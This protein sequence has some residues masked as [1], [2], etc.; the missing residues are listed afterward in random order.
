MLQQVHFK[1]WIL[2]VDKEATAN[3]Y[4]AVAL[5]GSQTCICDD[6]KKYS[7]NVETIIPDNIK[8]LF[9]ELGIDHQKD[10]EVTHILLD[11][12]DNICSG[13]FH[14]IGNFEGPSCAMPASDTGYTLQLT[15]VANNFNIGFHYSDWLT[16]FK[17]N[18]PLV[19]VEFS[20][21]IPWT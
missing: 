9:A 8:H 4:S 10:A 15:E 3:A 5:G 1:D 17:T 11:N 7:K 19:Q 14:F 18:N 6:C 21:Q 12:G 20:T 2:M 13:W 16:L